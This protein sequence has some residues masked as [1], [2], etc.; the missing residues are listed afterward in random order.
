MPKATPNLPGLS[1][2][3]VRSLTASFDGGR[4]SS[5]GGLIVLREAAHRLG[6]TDVITRDCVKAHS[7]WQSEDIIA[8]QAFEFSHNGL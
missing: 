7:G 5:D 6:L 2:L 8:P 4:L 3:G 1:A